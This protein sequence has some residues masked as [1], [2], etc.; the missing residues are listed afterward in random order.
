MATKRI[1]KLYCNLGPVVEFQ[2]AEVVNITTN[3]TQNFTPKV[4]PDPIFF[5]V[6]SPV[7]HFVG[8]S[9]ELRRLE[10]ALGI[11]PNSSSTPSH[12]IAVSGLGGIGKTQLVRKFIKKNRL[13]YRNVIWINSERNEL[14]IESLKTLAR[15]ELNI[16]LTHEDGREKDFNSVVGQLLNRLSQTKTLFVNDNVD[17]I[18]SI[19]FLLTTETSG[20]KPHFI[21]TSRIR[22]WGDGIDVIH[23]DAWNVSDAIE[24]VATVLNHPIDSDNDKLLLVDRLEAFPL[25]LRQ[26]TAYIKYQRKEEPVYRIVD[27]VEKYQTQEMLDCKLFQKDALN[28]YEKTTFTT[29]RVTI[30]AIEQD[31]KYGRLA[32][33]ILHVIAFFDP[34]NIQRSVFFVHFTLGNEE[35]VRA[36]INLLVNYSMVDCQ[37]SKSVLNVHRLVQQVIKLKLQSTHQESLILEDGLMLMAKLIESENLKGNHSHAISIFL[38][39]LKFDTLVE[40]FSAMP[41]SIFVNLME[42]GEFN[43]AKTFGD[44]VLQSFKNLFGENHPKTLE[45][46]LTTAHSFR[47]LGLHTSALQMYQ[48]VLEKREIHLGE[49]HPDTLTT[50]FSTAWSYRQLGMHSEAVVMY[51]KVLK[52]WKEK[53]GDDH[54]KTLTCEANIAFSYRELG[55]HDKALQMYQEV[56]GKRQ[57]SLGDAHPETLI[58]EFNIAESYR[59]L[60]MNTEAAQMYPDILLKWER[61]IGENHPD[62]LIAKGNIATAYKDLGMYAKALEMYQEVYDK[63]KIILG[64]DHTDTLKSKSN[65]ALLYDELGMHTKALEMSEEVFEKFK[66]ILGEDHPETLTSKLNLAH[67]YKE[68][69]LKTQALQIYREVYEIERTTL[70]EDHPDNLIS[71]SNIALLLGELG[72]HSEALDMSERVLEQIKNVL[73]ENHPSTLI[74]QSNIAGLY[75]ESGMKSEA[76]EM[77]KDIFE[78]HKKIVGEDHQRTLT[79]E[80]NVALLYGELGM[81]SLAHKMFEEV[82]EKRKKTLGD[83]HLKTIQSK[84]NVAKF[85]GDE[86]SYSSRSFLSFRVSQK[87][88]SFLIFCSLFAGV[89]GT[90]N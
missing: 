79:I 17:E 34:D 55:M 87:I 54:P 42:G 78:R 37:E 67:S 41:H 23:L 27:Y 44:K 20:E 83:D 82:F 32:A 51:Q 61:G 13:S 30:D 3:I 24:Y 18:E 75:N 77:F 52:K 60:G 5:R 59:A 12:I 19:K 28:I 76:L 45:V 85:K 26:A 22:E 39:A 10:D 1:Q 81:K 2:E 65:V 15:D 43:R 64:E 38:A 46:T 6:Q 88:L 36:A 33:R 90:L 58:T 29:W 31:A 57:N 7:I 47:Q 9:S 8:R 16:P 62:T 50:R 84:A 72:S 86:F 63:E 21:I 74:I 25:A 89:D 80:S 56:F 4:S 66:K 35:H 68:L 73:G 11:T 49:D 71:K 53:F 70:R 48:N 40:Q 14:I 69:G